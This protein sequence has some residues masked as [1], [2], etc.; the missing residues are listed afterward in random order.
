[1]NRF[2]TGWSNVFRR[3]QGVHP[4]NTD[5][6]ASFLRAA[7]AGNLEKVLEY[8]KGSIDINTSNANGLNALHLASKEGHVTVVT[9]LLKRGANVDA[10]TK[11][12]NTALH[13]ASLAGRDEIVKILIQHGASVNVQSQN[14]FT[15]LYMAAQENHDAVVKFLLTSG[16]NQSLATED[17]FTPLAV[18]LQQGHDK[19]VTVLLEN[20][21]RGKVRLPALHI[22]SKKDDCKAAALLLQNDHNPDVTSK[23]GFTPL[24]IAAHYGNENIAELLLQRGADVN[25]AAKHNITPLHVAAKWGK[26]NMV[27]VLVAKNATIDAKTRDGLTPLHCAA[28][29]GHDQCVDLLLER[30]AYITAKTKNGLAPLHMAA[31][32]DHL[33]SAR[34]ILYHKAPVDDV[35]MDYLTALHVSAHCGHVRVAKLLLDRKADANARALNGFTPLHI[36]C[37]KNRIKV[38]ELLLKHGASIEATTES[39]LTPLHV[40]AF[41]GCMNILIFLIQHGSNPD[42]PTVRGETPLHLAA[43]ANQIDNIRILLRNGA[44]VDARAREQQTP[45]HIASRLGNSDV[46]ALLLQHGAAVDA[47]TKDMYTALHIASKEEQDDVVSVLL[48]H[49]AALAATT[50]KGFTPLHLAAKYGNMKVT[51]LLLQKDAPVDAQGKNGVTP[52]HVAAHYDHQNVALLLLDKGAS[53]HATAKNGYTPLHIAA[54]KNQMDIATTLLEYG[55]QA[56]AES[57]AGFTPLHLASQEGHTDMTTLLLEHHAD[58]NSKAKNGL[59][60]LHLAAQEDRVN[61]AAILV[62]SGAEIDPK[63]KAGYTPLHVAC[64]FGQ[65]NMVR[66]LL[67]HE[68]DVNA[69]TALGYTPLHQAAQ[70]GHTTVVNL[71]LEHKASPNATTNQGQTALSIAQRLG[72]ISVVETLKVVTETIITTTTTTITEEKYKVVAPETMQ[73]TFMSDSEEEGGDDYME[74][75]IYGKPAHATHVYLPYYE[76]QKL[77]TL[78]EDNMFG[79]QSYRY[80]TV[81]EMKSLGDDSLP[82]DPTRDEKSESQLLK[83]DMIVPSINDDNRLSPTIYQ[84]SY[85]QTYA[86]FT[87]DYTPDN[88]DV[89]RSPIQAGKLK[90]KTF[91]VSFMVDARGGAMRGCRHSGVRVIIPPRKASMPTRITCRYLKKEKLLHP[92][93]LM[94]GEACASRVLE[95]GPIGAKFLGPVIIEVP[96][97]ASLRG[98]EREIVI[99]R[100]DNGENWREHTLEATEE[101]VQEVLNESFDGEELS[102]LEDLNT[103]RITRILTTDFPQYFAVVTRVRQEVHTIGP[104]GGMVSSTVVPQVQAVFPDNALT[105]KIKVGLQAQPIPAE[106]VAKL[107]GNRV[108]VS[109]IVTVEPRRRKFHKPIVLTIPV[110]QAASKGM[111]NQYSGDAPTLRLLCSITGGTTRAQWEDVTGST[112]YTF[113]ND[114][115]SFQ[116]TVSA[117]FWLMDCLNINEATK[118]ATDLYRE[119]IYVP[120]MAKFCVF[121]KRHDPMEARLRVFCMTDDKEE[122][123]LESQEHFI[124]VAKS[125]DVEVLEGKEQFVEFAGNLV[126]VTK[127]GEQLCLIF[128][129]FRENRLPFTIR[130][131]DPHQDPAGRIAFMREAR[132]GRGEPPQTPICNLNIALPNVLKPDSSPDS[133]AIEKKMDYLASVGLNKESIHR[134]ELRL[135]DIGRLL[136]KDWTV[137][138]F[139]LDLEESDVNMIKSDIPDDVVLQATAM[140]RLWVQVSGNKATGNVLEKALR[141]INR[142][143]IVEQCIFN[144]ELVTDDVEKAVAKVHLDQSGFDTFKEELGSSREASLRRDMSFDASYEEQDIMKEAES[145][146]ETSSETGSLPDRHQHGRP[147]VYDSEIPAKPKALEKDATHKVQVTEVKVEKEKVVD[148]KVSQDKVVLKD[149]DSSEIG[150]IEK[151]QSREAEILSSIDE[152]SSL[153]NEKTGDF[154]EIRK[155]EVFEQTVETKV[156]DKDHRHIDIH[157]SEVADLNKT[158]TTPL[159]PIH[160]IHVLETKS[161]TAHDADLL[162]YK[163]KDEIDIREMDEDSHLRKTTVITEIVKTEIKEIPVRQIEVSET[164]D[165][166]FVTDQGTAQ[167]QRSLSTTED[168]TVRDLVSKFA[169][170]F[171]D[172]TRIVVAEDVPPSDAKEISEE[173]IVKEIVVRGDSDKTV[174]DHMDIEEFVSKLSESFEDIP[175]LVKDRYDDE[176]EIE[177]DLISETPVTLKHVEIDRS[178]DVYDKLEKLEKEQRLFSSE[179]EMLE[180][181]YKFKSSEDHDDI[182]DEQV[183]GSGYM[184]P[185][186]V[187][188]YSVDLATPIIVEEMLKESLLLDEKVP[189]ETSIPQEKV[190]FDVQPSAVEIREI[191][192]DV[193]RDVL[194]EVSVTEADVAAVDMHEDLI[195]PTEV[196]GEMPYVLCPPIVATP[197]EETHIGDVEEWEISEK[198]KFD[199]LDESVIDYEKR[200]REISE[201]EKVDD[202]RE[203]ITSE[204]VPDVIKTTKTP[205][206]SPTEETFKGEGLEAARL[207][208]SETWTSQE[209][210][211]STPDLLK[212]DLEVRLHGH[213]DDKRKSWEEEEEDKSH[214]SDKDWIKHDQTEATVVSKVDISVKESVDDAQA[215]KKIRKVEDEVISE[216]PASLT[217]ETPVDGPESETKSKNQKM[218]EV[219]ERVAE[220]ASNLASTLEKA[221]MEQQTIVIEKSQIP[222]T[223]CVEEISQLP[224][225]D[226]KPTVSHDIKPTDEITEKPKSHPVDTTKPLS[227][228]IIHTKFDQVSSQPEQ[229]TRTDEERAVKAE[230]KLLVKTSDAGREAIEIRSIKEFV[231][232]DSSKKG[233]MSRIFAETVASKSSETPSVTGVQPISPKSKT[234]T[235]PLPEPCLGSISIAYEEPPHYD[236][237]EVTTEDVTQYEQPMSS[238][239]F[240]PVA[241]SE[242]G[243]EREI[244]FETVDDEVSSALNVD[245]GSEGIF[246]ETQSTSAFDT[247]VVAEMSEE[248]IIRSDLPPEVES[249]AIITTP[250]TLRKLL[251][252]PRAKP[253]TYVIQELKESSVESEVKDSTADSSIS[254]GSGQ[255]FITEP[256]SDGLTTEQQ[257]FRHYSSPDLQGLSKAE[258]KTPKQDVDVTDEI[259]REEHM[260]STT[261]TTSI[262]TTSSTCSSTVVTTTSVLLTE[263]TVLSKLS[264]LE[265]TSTTSN[266]S[267]H[268]DQLQLITPSSTISELSPI[269]TQFSLGVSPTEVDFSRET[270]TIPKQEFQSMIPTKPVVCSPQKS[271]D[272]LFRVSG[273]YSPLATQPSSTG[274]D[275]HES[276]AVV[277]D[278]SSDT[279][280]SATTVVHAF[281]VVGHTYL[282]QQHEADWTSSS[283]LTGASLMSDREES[284]D[285]DR[286]EPSDMF[287]MKGMQTVTTSSSSVTVQHSD[288]RESEHLESSRLSMAFEN[289]AFAGVDDIDDDDDGDDSESSRRTK[290]P[291]ELVREFSDEEV[292]KHRFE[293]E[294]IKHE[295]FHKTETVESSEMYHGI[296]DE[297]AESVEKHIRSEIF[298]SELEEAIESQQ[299]ETKTVFLNEQSTMDEKTEQYVAQRMKSDIFSEEL[300]HNLDDLSPEQKDLPRFPP[301]TLFTSPY[302]TE[303]LEKHGQPTKSAKESP[304]EPVLWE[305]SVQEQVLS[306]TSETAEEIPARKQV[307]FERDEDI[308]DQINDGEDESEPDT[309]NIEDVEKNAKE[310]SLSAA[311]ARIIAQGI[312]DEIKTEVAKRPPLRHIPS[313][314]S[315]EDLVEH[316]EGSPDHSIHVQVSHSIE[317]PEV[318]KHKITITETSSVDI[319]DEELRTSSDEL[320]PVD[321]QHIIHLDTLTS[322][323]NLRRQSL[324]M[325]TEEERLLTEEE[326]KEWRTS[327]YKDESSIIQS[328]E[329]TEELKTTETTDEKGKELVSWELYTLERDRERRAKQEQEFQEVVKMRREKALEQRERD[330]D[331]V[332]P[333]FKIDDGSVAIEHRSSGGSS[334]ESPYY[335]AVE[336]DSGQTSRGTPGTS[337]PCSSDVET[338]VT[339]GHSSSDYDTC[340]NSAT[341]QEYAT[342][343]SSF[344]GQSSSASIESESS[345]G[346]LASVEVSSEAS[347]TLMT[348]ALELERDNETPTIDNERY[349]GS[350][351]QIREPY[352]WEIPEHVIRGQ[353]PTCPFPVDYSYDSHYNLATGS[354]TTKEE[355]YRQSQYEYLESGAAAIGGDYTPGSPFE[356]I[357]SDDIDEF[358]NV[359]QTAHEDSSTA[360]IRHPSHSPEQ[361][362]DEDFSKRTDLEELISSVRF[363]SSD[364]PLPVASAPPA[365]DDDVEEYEFVRRPDSYSQANGPVEVEFHPEFDAGPDDEVPHIQHEPLDVNAGIQ[366]HCPLQQIPASPL[367]QPLVLESPASDEELSEDDSGMNGHDH[368]T[369][370]PDAQCEVP[371]STSSYLSDEHLTASVSVSGISGAEAA[372]SSSCST[373]I[374][375]AIDYERPESE[376]P[377]LDLSS[378]PQSHAESDSELQRPYSE[379]QFSDDRPDSE[380]TDL[381]KLSEEK[382]E[383]L[384]AEI[385]RPLSPE[386]LEEYAICE[387]DVS[388]E[389]IDKSSLSKDHDSAHVTVLTPAPE[390]ATSTAKD[391]GSPHE[392]HEFETSERTSVE[393]SSLNLLTPDIPDIKVTQHVTPTVDIHYEFPGSGPMNKEAAVLHRLS[394]VKDDT[395]E[396]SSPTKDLKKDVENDKE[397][398]VQVTKPETVEESP[399]VAFSAVTIKP[400]SVQYYPDDAA[401]EEKQCCSL[402]E[403][404]DFESQEKDATHS[405]NESQSPAASSDAGSAFAEGAK[406]DTEK[407]ITMQFDDAS[408]TETSSTS[409]T[410]SYS[411][412]MEFEREFYT[413]DE[414]LEDILEEDEKAEI[415]LHLKES[416]SSTPDY[417]ILAGKKYFSK[418]GEHDDASVSSLQEFE[419]L[420]EQLSRRLSSDSQESLNGGNATKKLYTKSGQGDD[421]SINSLQE[422]ELMEKQCSEAERIERLANEEAARLSEIEEGH[423][424]Q[425]SEAE[426]QETLSE[427]GEYDD[428]DSNSDDYEKRMFEIDEIIKQAQSNVERF[429]V[430]TS[431]AI[432]AAAASSSS[433]SNSA[434]DKLMKRSSSFGSGDVTESSLL[435]DKTPSPGGDDGDDDDSLH[436]DQIQRDTKEMDRDS[437]HGDDKDTQFLQHEIKRQDDDYDSDSLKDDDCGPVKDT[438]M[439]RSAEFDRDS[440]TGDADTGLAAGLRVALS[441]TILT[442]SGHTKGIDT[443]VSS[444]DSLEP[445]SSTATHATYHYETDS[446]MSSSFASMQTSAEESTMMSSTDVLDLDSRFAQQTYQYSSSTTTASS[447]Q[448]RSPFIDMESGI[449]SSANIMDVEGNVQTDLSYSDKTLTDIEGN[450]QTVHSYD[451]KETESH[452]EQRQQPLDEQFTHTFHR[453]VV[454]EPDLRTVTFTGPDADAKLKEF[455]SKFKPGDDVVEMETTDDQGNV[456]VTRTVQ[457]RVVMPPQISKLSSLEE[458]LDQYLQQATAAAASGDDDSQIEVETEVIEEIDEHGR[459]KKITKKTISHPITETVTFSGPDAKQQMEEALQ[460]AFEGYEPGN[461]SEQMTTT[462][463]YGNVISV[464]KHSIQVTKT[465]SSGPLS[466]VAKPRTSVRV[467]TTETHQQSQDQ[468]SPFK[469]PLSRRREITDITSPPSSPTVSTSSHSEDCYCGPEAAGATSSHSAQSAAIGSHWPDGDDEDEDLPPAMSTP[470]RGPRGQQEATDDSFNPDELDQ[471][472]T[473]HP[474]HKK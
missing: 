48:D 238:G 332:G 109:P 320:S 194:E 147:D 382:E 288:S 314:I 201:H 219:T 132:V 315:E 412:Q 200:S 244:V 207:A 335:S 249:P 385:E 171:E 88:I 12:G 206:S 203:T 405:D 431:S 410:T 211:R 294:E 226:Q 5:G 464:V 419:R 326:H 148:G 406:S 390:L 366:P 112:P 210:D 212:G 155:T 225:S 214:G 449:T 78:G 362:N 303:T 70:Q 126:P 263:S 4:R 142:E 267:V 398:I 318:D 196:V 36:A 474:S 472:E 309:A 108:A 23:S 189:Q 26:I 448:K 234:S 174:V 468:G 231:E 20:D 360:F 181:T 30:G 399:P 49:G 246:I 255:V 355:S 444:T 223:V 106:L 279:E 264:P 115:V 392:K 290:S 293:S 19:V 8:L 3:C 243:E 235:T 463:D 286:T 44:H 176:Q 193:D 367:P 459:V 471:Q 144:V 394:D 74:S 73:E 190:Y 381:M 199:Q 57:K 270:E 440:L 101:A 186:L 42:V 129:A 265:P 384:E 180:A 175:S 60:P 165:K 257:V 236:V 151:Q 179:T 215:V 351:Q 430:E 414:E 140:L 321:Q 380:L 378:R 202:Q 401:D 228:D 451:T 71:L 422:F 218:I 331:D 368:F 456:H 413:R 415:P 328:S 400:L 124:E 371:I 417:D 11:K 61:V 433:T 262:T 204:H 470:A 98:K 154:E 354:T 178:D 127:S 6:N 282:V 408:K 125:R 322:E 100:S 420:E 253:D 198:S 131:R 346:N 2:V 460:Q 27:Q 363:R 63:T 409:T 240:E 305:V 145:A 352:E 242:F 357:S 51:R 66:F 182:Y 330:K 278:V 164:I 375:T 277:S 446:I 152:F 341:S 317:E 230:I 35:T 86:Q 462:D 276:A 379:L 95:M 138:A 292:K 24:H 393:K 404:G 114:C 187:A 172:S 344:R 269:N 107:L 374:I 343:P 307:I 149:V 141:K 312:V 387:G 205:P 84:Q 388:E 397:S 383:E 339:C 272:E 16:A 83:E 40:A 41:M 195:E 283:S 356:I 209:F 350:E 47:A 324:A 79:D 158:D 9:E 162:T 369:P 329:T 421:S 359:A 185:Q 361:R 94:E 345:S 192:E 372:M 167:V 134:A 15:P 386:P 336:T 435:D 271:L 438:K 447:P 128:N 77:L 300:D 296:K 67:Q 407:W 50:K 455:I 284:F 285:M 52:L 299:P 349:F 287:G 364:S 289:Q 1:M 306:E 87:G 188:Q 301:T 389:K 450:V 39:G 432:A 313:E 157:A 232:T 365:E 411:Y 466:P 96:H 105:K 216:E 97:F 17:G 139:Q 34:I 467:V 334:G 119:A 197:T 250:T 391:S 273:P 123:T 403:K 117:R 82:M 298:T 103:N 54:K 31:Q 118:M 458:D 281:E 68:A 43:R 461:I 442:A 452:T 237:G 146:E 227:E 252:T 29:S 268:V 416:K 102:A 55:A 337:R 396:E 65:M 104:E 10:A 122:K 169:E 191:P 319:S 311:E 93:P 85:Q 256:P 340:Q 370:A 443:M 121:A 173:T 373:S 156:V 184:E 217:A 260:S 453:S 325:L 161:I 295:V 160:D 222:T 120:F 110:P 353:I 53:P 439:S 327:T 427:H 251:L 423:E 75:A 310:S 342:A 90:W 168:K 130:V 297:R 258:Q 469:S 166:A 163:T 80:L 153:L 348:S 220:V 137:L 465:S 177:D 424:S 64:H 133:L 280:T 426:S 183:R 434:K 136:D 302:D 323:T 92:P 429:E 208:E 14:G 266:A 62:K 33:D 418:S 113:V 58:P 56:N 436:G 22:A 111:L 333:V 377:D 213:L 347:E 221:K 425:V 291:F 304:A 76:G 261:T 45:L 7:R 229:P 376:L 402:E 473:I 13:I 37:K 275:N 72:Y 46:V 59:S 116:T 248:E 274:D 69:I 143:D 25:Y 239:S 81:D 395:K 441:G 358:R 150:A 454:M 245:V 135:S 159:P 38:V 259:I 308:S 32:G 338:L 21:T 91:L 89:S 316:F 241:E 437:L 99:L 457:H 247:P 428:T 254:T 224:T 445:S 170:S 28:R 233:E 18:A